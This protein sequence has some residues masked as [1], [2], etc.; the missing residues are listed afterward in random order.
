MRSVVCV[1]LLS[2]TLVAQTV[3]PDAGGTFFVDGIAYQYSAGASCTVVVAAHSVINHKFLALKVRVYN[4]G[5]RSLTLKPED[6]VVSDAVGN[7]ELLS[8]SG[9]EMARRLRKPYNMARYA[10]NGL[11]GPS[12]DSPIT[13][14]MLNPQLLEMMRVMAAHGSHASTAAG[15]VLYT[16]TPGA[17]DEDGPRAQAVCDQVCVLRARETQGTDPIAEL[18]RQISPDTVESFALRAN[19][20]PPRG[21]VSGILYFPLNKL[22]ENS[23]KQRIVLV[24]LPIADAHFSF[25]L[26]VE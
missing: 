4:Q 24:S 23:R 11:G 7:H 22:S 14:D 8:I 26:P 18:Q 6:F 5:Q 20:I 13:S 9:D 3:A 2:F 16:D 1:L 25:E 17:L 19:T 10:V 21:N 15:N 12:T